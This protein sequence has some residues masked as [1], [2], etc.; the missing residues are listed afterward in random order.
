MTGTGW[1]VAEEEGPADSTALISSLLTAAEACGAD[2]GQLARDAE[3][4]S[5][6]LS[7]GLPMMLP[8]RYARRVWE[9]TEHALGTADVP[10]AMASQSISGRYGVLDYLF[11]TAP[12]VRDGLAA[13]AGS[14]HLWTTNGRTRIE[15]GDDGAVTWSYYWRVAQG[16]RGE[17]LASQYLVV[18]VM[19]E[20][21]VVTGRSVVPLQ[22]TFAHDPPRSHRALGEALGPAQLHFGAPLT[23]VTFR[24]RDL[25]LPLRGADPVLAGILARYAE[26]LPAPPLADWPERFRVQL[27]QALAAGTPTLAEVAR[28][29]AASTRTVQRRLAEHGTTWRAELEA[30]RQLLATSS[31]ADRTALARRLGYAD[32]RSVR[33]ALRQWESRS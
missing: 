14:L 5:W 26:S 16:G 27:A 2:V 22:V 29:M 8:P 4:P 1:V 11:G 32:S 19:R 15:T 10:L 9:L 25:D 24:A 30:A 21:Q 3:I 31:V 7:A 33:R 12:T 6:A 28:R 13:V 23:T 18:S 20:I 17:G